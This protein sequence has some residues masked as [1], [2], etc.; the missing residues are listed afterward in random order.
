MGNVVNTIS[1]GWYWLIDIDQYP[2]QSVIS[3]MS[4][5]SEKCLVCVQC[6]LVTLWIVVAII[7]NFT[8]LRKKGS[9][10]GQMTFP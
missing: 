8:G 2:I 6:N 1:K 3:M 4:V 5:C 7:T 10:E 9:H